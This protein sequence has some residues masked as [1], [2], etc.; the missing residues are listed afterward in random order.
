MAFQDGFYKPFSD[1][2]IIELMKLFFED[3]DQLQPLY[4][5]ELRKE[6]DKRAEHINMFSFGT[7]E[8]DRDGTG[9]F[10]DNSGVNFETL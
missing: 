8:D 3:D 6:F 5:V 1:T 2:V 7:F 9:A 4:P 10:V